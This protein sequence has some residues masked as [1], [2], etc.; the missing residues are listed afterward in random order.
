MSLCYCDPCSILRDKAVELHA[1]KAHVM[2]AD[3]PEREKELE[4]LALDE[5]LRLLARML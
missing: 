1:R 2:L 3:R 4:L 5:D